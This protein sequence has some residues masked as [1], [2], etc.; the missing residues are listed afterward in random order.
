MNII[1][2]SREFGSGGRELGKRLADYLGVP[3]YDHEIIDMVAEKHG[4]DKNYVSLLSEK[5]V[6]VFYP[7]TIGHRFMAPA[8]AAQQPVRVALAQHEIIRS[9][10]QQSDC[11]IVG[12][13]ADV[14][15]RDMQPLNLFVYADKLSK[16]VR[17][18]VRAAKTEALSEREMLRRM[19]QI[20]K[21]RAAYRELFTEAEWGRKE[22]YHLCVNTSGKEIK[23]LV[24]G[25]GEYAKAWFEQK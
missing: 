23:A 2:I 25:I 16:L 22:S 20:D 15:C 10:A 14:V 7:S 19:K 8:R 1:T 11:V 13:C 17:C 4:F 18:Q 9:L 5:D 21:D 6:R 12:R 3:C 24:P